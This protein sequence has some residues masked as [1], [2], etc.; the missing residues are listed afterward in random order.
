MIIRDK[1]REPAG[2][3]KYVATG[4]EIPFYTFGHSEDAWYLLAGRVEE[5]FGPEGGT[6]GEIYH[7]VTGPL[8]LSLATTRELV[9]AAKKEGYLR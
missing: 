3:K 2:Q 9:R 8:G 5:E 1:W 4:K 7:Q 6:L